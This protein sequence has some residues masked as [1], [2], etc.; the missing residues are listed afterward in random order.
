MARS[1]RFLLFGL[2]AG[3]L[4]P[5]VASSASTYTWRVPSPS[6]SWTSSSSWI[7]LRLSPAPDDILVFPFANLDVL[8]VPTET[9]GQL[10]FSP[11][12]DFRFFASGAHTL[13]IAGNS[14]EDFDLP[15][16]ATLDI[17]GANA[18]QI[19]LGP[20][21][22]GGIGGSF[23][24]DGAAHRLLAGDPGALVV[25]SG[26]KVSTG[27]TFAGNL[28][29]T[30]SLNSVVF[31]NGSTYEH[32]GGANPFGATQ[33][34][35]VVTF[36]PGS[37]FRLV[38]ALSPSM[39]GRTYANFEYDAPGSAN[40]V[41]SSPLSIDSISV[42]Q[43][44]FSLGLS[45]PVSLRGAIHVA[46]GA[47]LRLGPLA[48]SATYTFN[49]VGTQ[50]V[51][52]EHNDWKYST[53]FDGRP[54]TTLAIDNPA[55]VRFLDH[56]PALSCTIQFVHGSMS[57]YP[58]VA[59]FMHLFGSGQ[60]IGASASTGWLDG[61]LFMTVQPASP[62]R[63]FPIGDAQNYAPVR[64]DYH[65]LTDSLEVSV[66]SAVPQGNY[67]YPYFT[68]AQI[69][70][71]KKAN[72]LWIISE[73][74]LSQPYVSFDATVGWG[75]TDLDV[76]ADPA[77]FVF[78]AKNY[79]FDYYGTPYEDETVGTRTATS[80]QALGLTRHGPNNTLYHLNV[81]EPAT[82]GINAESAAIAEGAAPGPRPGAASGN[83]LTFPVSILPAS[84][85]TVQVAYQV[86][87][88]TATVADGD[89]TPTS[90]TL[91]FAPGD[92]VEYVTVPIIGDATPERNE[93]V[94]LELTNPTNAVIVAGEA[95]GTVRDDDD[96]TPPS[97]SVIAPNGGETFLAGDSVDLQWNATDDVAVNA[98]TLEIS[99]DGG[100]TYETIA[101]GVPNTGAY[102]W[103]ANEPGSS[104]MFLRVSA[105]D[106][107]GNAGSDDSDGAWALGPAVGL[108]PSPVLAFALSP[109]TPNPARA[110]PDLR[111]ALPR[112][113]QVE[114]AI[115][116]VRG[117]LVRTVLRG[118][119]PAG[120]HAAAWSAAGLAPG[121]YFARFAAADF[122][123]VERFVILH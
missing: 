123:T 23:R 112:A 62:S 67:Y 106:D 37:L 7:P 81:G 2:L 11:G 18:L 68:M 26:G 20:G 113:S 82:V 36:Q 38:T 21:A 63:T 114:L 3:S 48:G 43:G 1:I 91:T 95:T 53:S 57:I 51:V 60:M 98:V 25:H 10:L 70:S 107:P 97:V 118:I 92:T 119:E 101:T 111:Y 16:T 110:A 49:G 40:T 22:T 122:Q 102:A 69:D 9:V 77:R 72:R 105:S 4:L 121:L 120:H 44:T 30:G 80:I 64:L 28:F 17:A 6:G 52:L 84:V 117:R 89:Y 34:N 58:G 76:G 93:T 47:N 42:K 24:V 94:R 31:E 19:S 78:R 12:A 79:G 100:A 87:D 29:G 33:P 14:G 116:D 103:T 50:N 74:Q 83:T 56:Q 108:D 8:N 65:G 85:S 15:A 75:A 109:V 39:S 54:G 71:T 55:G 61:N 46:N 35:S 27:S 13:T 45:A 59:S 32:G 86:V 5:G 96:V 115:L 99:R 90:G 73:N 41:G 88:G 104:S 66:R